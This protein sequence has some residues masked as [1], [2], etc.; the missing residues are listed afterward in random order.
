[1]SMTWRG[2]C[3]C[4]Y[5]PACIPAAGTNITARTTAGAFGDVVKGLR[6][7]YRNSGDF[8]FAMLTQKRKTK[9]VY[10]CVPAGEPCPEGWKVVLGACGNTDGGGGGG[11]N[12]R[13]FQS[14]P[15]P[16]SS[17]TSAVFSPTQLTLPQGDA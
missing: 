9:L 6:R 16:F 11:G 1:V 14:P 15:S 2:I 17:S 8:P 10:R 13:D 4:P 3:A 7:R 5:L 12:G